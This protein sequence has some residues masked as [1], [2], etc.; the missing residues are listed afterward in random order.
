MATMR[1]DN[2][3]LAL[4][5]LTAA[6]MS[7]GGHVLIRQGKPSKSTVVEWRVN[8]RGPMNSGGMSS[9]REHAS[10]CAINGDDTAEALTTAL[11]RAVEW[12]KTAKSRPLKKT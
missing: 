3:R 5:L 6:S 12:L 2:N 8:V 10:S 11:E 4:L 9:K 1:A 7:A